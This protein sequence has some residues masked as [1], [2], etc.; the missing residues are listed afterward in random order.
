MLKALNQA[1]IDNSINK[2]KATKKAY[3]AMLQ[4]QQAAE[5]A[6]RDALARGIEDDIS[7]WEDT[8]SEIE[9]EVSEAQETMMQAWEDALQAAADAFDLA[10]ET[11]VDTFEKALTPFTSLD[12]FSE[13]Y[14]Q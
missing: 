13:A 11:A 8:L 2:V 5:L 3:D 7:Y 12:E 14:D 9:K 1:T 6:Y 10:V 4:S